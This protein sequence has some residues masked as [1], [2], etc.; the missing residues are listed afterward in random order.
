MATVYSTQ[1]A[2]QLDVFSNSPMDKGYEGEVKYIHDSYSWTADLASG[3]QIEFGVLPAGTKVV[4]V[5]VTWTDMDNSDAATID[6]GYTGSLAAFHSNLDVSS[7]GSA[8]LALTT[9]LTTISSDVKLIAS[10]DTDSSATTGT[11]T[12]TC[13]FI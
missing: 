1:Y 12:V 9:G 3:L 6:V 7:A 10:I 4:D 2:K 5:I 8:R 13:L 11:I